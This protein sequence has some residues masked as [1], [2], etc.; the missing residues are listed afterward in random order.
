VK[1]LLRSLLIIGTV[2]LMP[3]MAT[4]AP[5]AVIVFDASG[6]MWG[7][8]NGKTKIEI[9]RD[10]LKNVVKDW[11]PDVELGVTAY[12]HRT[13]GDCNDIEA[14]IPVGKVDKKRVV[15]TVMHLQPKGKTPISR[16]LKKAADELKYTEE[17]ATIIL[18]SDGKETCDPDPCG[19]AKALKAQGIDF[20]TH[21][22]GFNVDKKTDEQL[23]CIAHATGGEYFSAKDAKA[24]N[25][26]IKTVAKK[27]EVKAQ[28]KPVVPK[29]D[30]NIEVSASEKEGGKWVTASCRAY[31]EA[32]DDSWGIY[33]KKK[34]L[35]K[36]QLPA[37]LYTLKCEYNAFKKETTFEVK[38]GEVTK[39]HM[40]M[41]QTGTVEVSVSEKDGG[42]WVAAS[43][44]AY[45]EA[46]DDSW[47]VYPKKKKPGSK[48]LPVGEYKLKC[49][50]NAFK[51]E[52]AFEV[53]P[54]ETTKV[55]LVMGQTGTVEVSASEKEGGK[56][57]AA[58]CRAYN[59]VLDDSWGIYP[60][61]KEPASKQLPVGVYKLK[62]EYLT[63]KK[64]TEFEV[65]PGE[66]TKVHVVMGQTGHV[67]VSASEKEGGKWIAAS[68]RAYNEALDNSWGIYPKKKEPASK[69]LP[70]GVYRLKCEYNGFNKETTFEVKPGETTKV[71][72]IFSPFL[73]GAKCANGGEKVSYE[74][75]GSDGRLVYD[76]TEPCSKTVKV[77]LSDGKYSVEAT[78]DG[79]KGEAQFVVGFGHPR[80]VIL[81]LTNLNHEE[82]IEAD[83]PEAVIVPVQQKKKEM[84]SE[85][86]S[87]ETGAIS[88]GGKKL[89]IKGLSKEEANKLKELGTM[90]NALGGM[91][92]GTNAQVVSPQGKTTD[93]TSDKE[94]D[95]MSQELDMF[96]K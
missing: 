74:I 14:V 1:V 51:A 3:L 21:V 28:P 63:F 20:V 5:K 42:K 82:E 78:I 54:G 39:V 6:S 15:E 7:Q 38:A 64:E 41:G 2:L 44:R 65:K 81:D 84:S 68:C 59:E 91:M 94:L 71:H 87:E 19:T 25:K 96:T 22:I 79:G 18:I 45:N 72:V 8:I 48:Q 35:A 13:K 95:E 89:E 69:H 88:I 80:K 47:G 58:S 4:D 57:I 61:K 50:Y 60:K 70:V 43:C 31:N 86:K 83:T 92:Q 49:E 56:W 17:K 9:A 33:P 29:L 75:Y 66:V 32:L 34:E 11:N 73:I 90:L 62:C 52:T 36:K 12:G 10:A 37:G 53:K 67:E 76:T 77:V 55:H 40:V 30:H 16:S 93:D 85:Q 27:V 26:A 24:L 46:L 23:A